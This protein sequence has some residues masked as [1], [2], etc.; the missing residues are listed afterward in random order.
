MSTIKG[1]EYLALIS[2]CKA[3]QVSLIIC[4]LIC[5]LTREDS[6][7]RSLAEAVGCAQLCCKRDAEV[8]KHS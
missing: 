3:F 5:W 4:S 1:T 7:C 8:L 6:H 2:M